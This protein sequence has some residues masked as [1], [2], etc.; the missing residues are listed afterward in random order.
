MKFDVVLLDMDGVLLHG[1]EP[2]SGAPATV[3]WLREQGI[4][5][6]VVTNSTGLSTSGF[7]QQLHGAGIAIEAHEIVTAVVGTASYLRTHY[8]GSSVFLLSDAAPADDLAGITL[9][10]EGA[11]VVVIGGASDEFTYGAVTRAFRMLMD[12]ANLVA[13]HRNRYW[14][15][16]DGWYL[17]GGAYVE[18][19]EKASGKE[20]MVCGKPSRTFFE[21]A[22]AGTGAEPGRAMMVGDDIRNDVLAAQE[23]GMTGVLVR[24]GKFREEDLEVGE[25]NHV[26]GG[27]GE[28]P[29]LLE[30]LLEV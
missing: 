13:M 2:I 18:A 11:D 21:A 26:I 5:F 25:A 28:L 14:R 24:T 29:A 23:T 12:G 10:E 9:V 19:L 6:R 20:A 30:A 27:V 22:L 16:E 1:A 17:D 8:R 15:A 7:A 4:P 3:A